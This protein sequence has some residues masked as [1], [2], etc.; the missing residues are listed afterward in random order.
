LH[1]TVNYFYEYKELGRM[2]KQFKIITIKKRGGGIRK[3]RVE[4]LSSGKFKFVKN[5]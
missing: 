1:H 2:T 3:Q 4:V 5:K